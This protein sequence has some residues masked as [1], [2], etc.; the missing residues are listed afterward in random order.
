ML[1]VRVCQ[2]LVPIRLAGLRERNE[3]RRLRAEGQVK[4]DEG[5]EIEVRDSYRIEKDPKRDD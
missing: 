5:I 1:G 3:G 4:Q 2:R